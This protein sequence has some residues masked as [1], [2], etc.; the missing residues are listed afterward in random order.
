MNSESSSPSA[1]AA[2]T[3]FGY[4]SAAASHTHRY[5]MPA[6]LSLGGERLRPRTRILDV[7]RGNGFTAG[8]L[9]ARG[10]EVVG[11]DPSESG[12]AIARENYPP[13]RFEQLTADH[14]LLEKR[15]PPR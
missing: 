11:I 4:R 10:C 14:G 7:G 8:Q 13:G 6:L 1:A 5:L 3:D 15:R 2:Y 12:I 9:L